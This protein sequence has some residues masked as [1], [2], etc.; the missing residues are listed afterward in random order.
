L[1]DQKIL[2]RKWKT[3]ASSSNISLLM[4][5]LFFIKIC[6]FMFSLNFCWWNKYR[7][8]GKTSF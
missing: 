5:F 4:G 7:F 6:T 1:F 8:E 2:R 3:E